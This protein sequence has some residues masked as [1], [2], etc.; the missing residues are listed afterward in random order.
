MT[1]CVAAICHWEELPMVFGASDRMI[2]AGDTEFEP[3]QSKIYQLTSSIAM[4]IA[5]DTAAQIEIRNH[6]LVEIGTRLARDTS[7]MPVA[8]AADV[9]SQNT[10]AYQRRRA[11]RT[12][13][14]PFGL[15]LDTFVRRQQEMSAVWV[16]DISDQILRCRPDT[17]TIV[18]GVDETGAHIFHINGT[19]EVTCRDAAAFSAIGWGWRHAESQ[20]MFAKHTAL[21]QFPETLRLAYTAKKRAEVAPGVG[22]D[23]DMFVISGLG[24][25]RE[26]VPGAKV[27][28]VYSALRAAEAT[29]TANANA[30]IDEHF[31]NLI[32]QIRA[33]HARSADQEQEAIPVAESLPKE[34]TQETPRP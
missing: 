11:E 17:A 31:K 19:G 9:V 20:F 10:V 1:V 15:T 13:L 6:V 14:T 27:E 12:I 23:T 7:W 3:P 16:R 8:E 5:G 22:I 30:A 18:A 2:T 25:Y 21:R 24:G 34:G 32:E 4:L 26:I 28:E 33:R 29:A